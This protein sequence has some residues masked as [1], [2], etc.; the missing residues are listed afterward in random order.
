[1]KTFAALALL[2]LVVA[3][4]LAW[5]DVGFF[6]YPQR[7]TN[8]QICFDN[9]DDYPDWAFYIERHSKD[10]E[11][12]RASSGE[13]VLLN[14]TGYRWFFAKLVA[15][16][17]RLVTRAGKMPPPKGTPGVLSANVAVGGEVL[18]LDL[19]RAY[20]TTYRV[21]IDNDKL[22][23]DRLRREPIRPELNLGIVRVPIPHAALF[24]SLVL[25]I[26]GLY[27]ARRPAAQAR[28]GPV[29][30]AT[31][32]PSPPSPAAPMLLSL[33]LTFL[34]MVACANFFRVTLFLCIAA[35][36]V[37][38][39]ATRNQTVALDP[40]VPPPKTRRAIR[41]VLF[42]LLVLLPLIAILDVVLGAEL[43]P[44][45]AFLA[46]AFACVLALAGCA[47]WY[48]LRRRALAP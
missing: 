13:V 23:I 48:V 33:L 17:K 3:V 47:G 8:Q 30:P 5:A 35:V 18:L 45:L 26:A 40:N 43:D 10:A 4:R 38:L 15:V 31:A 42:G 24:L 29:P 32:A 39:Y 11:P 12:V 14:N 34:V 27:H 41:T 20:R 22:E 16:P 2:W 19:N 21:T 36:V 9:L 37:G 6:P 1:M 46:F 44:A 28:P 7:L 25:M